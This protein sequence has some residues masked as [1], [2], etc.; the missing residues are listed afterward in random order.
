MPAA[1]GRVLHRDHVALVRNLD[2][3]RLIADAID[4]VSPESAT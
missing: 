2:R 1:A 4:D 3:L